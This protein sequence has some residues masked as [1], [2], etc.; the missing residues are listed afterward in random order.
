VK[1]YQL[2]LLSIFSGLLLSFAWPHS[3]FAPLIFIAFVPLFQ[4]EYHFWKKTGKAWWKVLG[5]SYI[6][7][8]IWNVLTTFWVYNSTAVGGIL[9]FSLNTLFMAMVF[10]LFHGIHKKFGHTI[11]Y[12]A[13]VCLWMSYEYLHQDWDLSWTWL[14]LGNVFS[15]YF[16]W[17]QW[18]EF[19]GFMGGTVWVLLVNILLFLGLNF[20]GALLPSW[21]NLR[22]SFLLFAAF[23]ILF[24]IGISYKIYSDYKEKENP[25]EIV[26]V[27]PNIDP[28][29]EK[30]DGMTASEQL[31]KLLRLAE[32]KITPTTKYVVG[33]ETALIE[34]IVEN[35]MEDF[36]SIQR[37][38]RFLK[39][40]P[41]VHLVVGISSYREYENG[42]KPSKTART[43][44]SGKVYDAYN[45]AAQ[46]DTTQFIQ[47]YHK[48]KLVPGVEKMPF[49]KLLKPLEELA[50]NLGGMSGSLGGQAERSVFVNPEDKHLKIAPVVCYESI[51]GEYV[52]EYVKNGAGLIFI[53]TNDGWWGDTPGYRQH[54]SYARLRA[55]EHRRSIA[56]SANTG[57]SCFVNQRGEISQATTYWKEA[58]IKESINENQSFT[59]YTLN[60]DY[61]AKT[62]LVISILLLIMWLYKSFSK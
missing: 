59:F 16:T 28:Y 60:G 46:I 42:E 39:V 55:I 49:P 44:P 20:E 33:P 48:S 34:G 21:S 32:S 22:Q 10:T 41:N 12:T 40:Y 50:F 26:V 27:Q 35:N 36:K 54:C 5:H 23:L 15:E 19:T 18:Y 56:R 17:I 31:I 13:L 25:V 61:L 2:Y 24:P 14:I 52:G 29:N 45:T 57:I 58:V 1:T 38:R 3:G 6:S 7:F 11:G 43:T 62:A 4:V 30:F 47:I 9:A 8:L 37:I 53:I 51:Y